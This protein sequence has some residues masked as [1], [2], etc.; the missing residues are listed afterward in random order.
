MLNSGN[1]FDRDHEQLEKLYRKFAWGG[2]R[3]PI[4]FLRF[5]FYTKKLVW[6]LLVGG[7][8]AFK[9]ALDMIGAILGLMILSPVLVLTAVAIKWEDRGPVFFI[10]DRVGKKGKVFRMFKFRSMIMGADGIK[11]QLIDQNQAGKII[12]KIKHDPRITGVGRIIRRLSID[13]LPQLVNVLKG[14]MSLVGPRPGL[15]GEV[16][17]YSVSE[18]RRL[19]VRPGIT[20]LWQVQ[21]RSE[22]D[23]EGQVSLDVQYI[24]SQSFCGDVIILLKTIPAVLSGKGAY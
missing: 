1:Q 3:I 4:W 12:F 9:R 5:R 13:E 21:G 10:Q 11:E 17:Q 24:E 19:E 6:T 7:A 15:P 8:L 14:D 16:Y 2:T 20:C 18:R 22:I 23:F